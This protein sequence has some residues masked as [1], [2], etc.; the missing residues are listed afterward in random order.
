M[1]VCLD[2]Q[3]AVG[4]GT[5][6]GRY[7]R[8][9]AR[10]LAAVRDPADR[11]AMFCFDFHRR[12]LSW[13]AP[14]AELRAC[15]WLPGRFVQKAWKSIGAPPFDL[16]SGP[17]DVFHF[18]NFILPP[19]RRGKSV[20][21]IH[22]V[23]FLRMPETIEEKNLAYLTTHIRR[24]V[25][26]ADAILAVSEFTRREIIELLN[27]PPEKVFAIHSG[28]EQPST[29]N[30]EPSTKHQEPNSSSPALHH[31]TTPFLLSLGTLEP[32][33]NYAFLVD[34]FE[35]M[36]FDG[37]LVIAGGRGWKFEPVL[38]R[39][40]RSPKRDRIR[41]PDYLPDADLERLYR[42]CALFV[43]PSRYE[44]FGFPPLEAMVRGAPVVSAATGSLP[45]VL[46]DAAELIAGFDADEWA[47]RLDAL[48]ADDTRRR[49]LAARGSVHAARFTWTE[50][51]RKTWDLYRHL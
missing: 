2:I 21:T 28:I 49:D 12:G 45:E 24:T 25:D 11:L 50:T 33:K 6:V 15:R 38:E 42:D 18:P 26:R 8:E 1:R 23:A 37:E 4:R 30:Q 51:A 47:A 19:L 7:T 40:A 5:G 34:V 20:V 27:V 13:T 48:V 43:L 31:S 32:R 35:R 16:F 46:G 9:L 17:A 3:S 14:G 29:K 10:G 22:D 36:K 41:L 44:G 39:I